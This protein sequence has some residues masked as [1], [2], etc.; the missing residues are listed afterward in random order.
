M[1]VR[2]GAEE[3]LTGCLE[4]YGYGKID[5]GNIQKSKDVSQHL[6]TATGII[7]RLNG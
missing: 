3:D 5:L 6:A 1:D 7:E 4:D 2:H